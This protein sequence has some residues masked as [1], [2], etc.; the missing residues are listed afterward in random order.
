MELAEGPRRGVGDAGWSA[1]LPS[2]NGG[3]PAFSTTMSIQPTASG[4]AVFLSYTSQDAEAAKR[5]AE[6]LRAAGVEV[7]FDKEELRGGDA[8]DRKIREQ[9][10]TCT[11]FVPVVSLRTEE[12]AEGYFRREWKLAADRTQ[13]MGS[14]RAFIVPVAIDRVQE[15][16]A[17]V[18]EE[19]MR[20]Q[21]TRLEGGVPTPEFVAQVQRLIEAPRRT[22][23]APAIP[24]AP[25]VR[26]SSATSAPTT[27][28][29]KR[30][31][32]LLGLAAVAVVAVAAA[33]YLG[34]RPKAAGP[35]S[36]A[37]PAA[38]TAAAA[39]A[40]V[41]VAEKSIAVLPFANMSEDKDNAFFADGV[42]EDILTN[43]ALIRELKV[44]SRTT[45]VRYR[46]A[47]KSV[48]EIGQELGVAFILEGSVRRMGNK[49]RVTGQLINSR[50]DEH[51]WAKAY[52]R[53]LTDIFAIQAALALEIAG[54]LEAAISP[55]TQKH[56]TRRPTENPAAHDLFLRGRD[57]RNR[58]PTA[59]RDAL[60]KAEQLFQSA[61]ELDPNFAAAWG[62]LAVVHALRVFWNHD[63]SPARL[64][65]ADAAMANARRI[66]PDAPDVIRIE[67]TF[68]YYAYRDYGRATAAYQRLIDRQPNDA[69]G[70][71]SLALILRRQGRWPEAVAAHAKSVELDPANILFL[72]DQ[73]VTYSLL[74]R[75]PEAGAVQQRLLVLLPGDLRE[76]FLAAEFA[77]Q[78]TGSL[79]A[80]EKLIAGL[81]PEQRESTFGR[82]ARKSLAVRRD[83]YAAFRAI[84][85][86]EPLFAEF[87][88]PVVA[89]VNTV[90]MH[91]R[92][93]QVELAVAAAKR[94]QAVC[95]QR[96][97]EEPSSHRTMIELAV[98]L[99]I[100]GRG[101][102][103]MRALDRVNELLPES[104]DAIDG[105]NY[106]ATWARV[107][108]LL[109]RKDEAV[110]ELRRLLGKPAVFT[111]HTLRLDP[112]LRHALTGYAPFDALVTDPK[113]HRPLP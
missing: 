60:A 83:D 45:V 113:N 62:E 63:A 19:F 110:E 49:V 57:T 61:V 31:P 104:R 65:R 55:E 20:Y 102:E 68:A 48:R 90:G 111:M 2:T 12:R 54:A 59:S 101:D 52:D 112:V 53:D 6:G 74:R 85:D 25:A 41:R 26:G 105:V 98:A 44:V 33:G 1:F 16:G 10:R 82:F 39:K 17:D 103:A 108:G 84:H 35:A 22:V 75:W 86:K 87:E 91:L 71:G 106:R 7:W 37:A 58:A 70:Y 9:I 5:L 4:K 30:S 80:L 36:P 76:Q 97:A 73:M 81:T 28:A 40:P 46:D 23:G 18:P 32:A 24:A 96:L 88:S 72:R 56:L 27:A 107:L 95:E 13:D 42:H 100:V 29:A 69:T 43:L 92:H 89:F 78:S 14:Q 94:Q 38:D 21:W 11:L 50:T 93:G 109:G 8:W 67:G 99:A 3:A 79:A 64:A 15:S 66:A 51:V 77:L 47:K 34:L